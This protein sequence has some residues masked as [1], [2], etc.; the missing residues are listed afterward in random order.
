MLRFDVDYRT[1][2]SR[3]EHGLLLTPVLERGELL[4]TVRAFAVLFGRRL[5]LPHFDW[6]SD[7]SQ[8]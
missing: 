3:N 6:A 2:P 1:N 5:Q 4:L 8:L 7:Y